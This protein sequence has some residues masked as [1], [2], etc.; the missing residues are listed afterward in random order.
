[1]NS[2]GCEPL[3]QPLYDISTVNPE[4]KPA[5]A[6]YDGILKWLSALWP[7]LTIWTAS[8]L[9]DLDDRSEAAVEQAKSD[10]LLKST[11]TQE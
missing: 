9:S 1:M 6:R 10:R 11:E 3:L 7:V 5:R 4:L 8:S 2:T